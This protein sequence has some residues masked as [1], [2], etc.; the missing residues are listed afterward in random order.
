MEVDNNRPASRRIKIVSFHAIYSTTESSCNSTE[1]A[2]FTLRPEV[3]G[4]RLPFHLASSVPH[5]HTHTHNMNEILRDLLTEES[6]SGVESQQAQRSL[7]LILSHL[8]SRPGVDD[9]V[10]FPPWCGIFIESPIPVVANRNEGIPSRRYL[11]LCAPNSL[12][13]FQ[14]VSPN[15]VIR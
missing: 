7:N 15:D 9:K 3:R 12:G 2:S 10:N 4:G 1:V 14:R 8:I 13:K 11:L 5:T 6:S